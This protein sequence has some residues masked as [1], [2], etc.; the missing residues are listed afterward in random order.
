[1][2]FTSCIYE[3]YKVTKT[4]RET[5]YPECDIGTGFSMF[6]GDVKAGAATPDNTGDILPDFDF[7][8]AKIAWDGMTEEE[9]DAA[10][11]EI[12]KVRRNPKLLAELDGL[13]PDR[14]AMVEAVEVFLEASAELEAPEAAE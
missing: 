8:A 14:M 2:N 6:L 9:K 7:A 13:Y 3:I 12:A 4:R 5:D 1:M 10:L 11:A